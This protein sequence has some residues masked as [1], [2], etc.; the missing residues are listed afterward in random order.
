MIT[1]PLRL[2]ISASWKH[3]LDN[4]IK[5]TEELV[6]K[7]LLMLPVFPRSASS[8]DLSSDY[9][10]KINECDLIIVILGKNYSENVNNEINY[11]LNNNKK[12]LCFVK[13]CERDKKLEEE[14]IELQNK[15]IVTKQFKDIED[16]KN[17][18]K[19][20]VIE[21]LSEKFKDYL[22]IERTILKLINDGKIE[23]LKPKSLQ[24]EYINVPRINPFEK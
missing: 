11:S 22:E 7:D 10:K 21:L 15:R 18:L 4:E 14:I 6:T 1:L 12:I 9:F 3:D 13:D 19:E 20:S 23:V 2:Y 17:S 16:L 8:R 24:S 5:I